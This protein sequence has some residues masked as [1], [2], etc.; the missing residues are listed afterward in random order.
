MGRRVIKRRLPPFHGAPLHADRHKRAAA[1]ERDEDQP[2]TGPRQPDQRV[3][4]RS[5]RVSDGRHRESATKF[6]I[7]AECARKSGIGGAVVVCAQPR[8]V[9]L[10]IRV[11]MHGR[12]RHQSLRGG[13]GT[14]CG[15][16]CWRDEDVCGGAEIRREARASLA[17]GR[18]ANVRAHARRQRPRVQGLRGQRV[19]RV[20]RLAEPGRAVLRALVLVRLKGG[21]EG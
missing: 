3:E 12:R 5:E 7:F 20:A 6:D 15:R 18:E 8:H 11:S 9:K 13:H 10:S 14:P 16:L 2:G 4:R 17:F 19:A 1:I 21:G